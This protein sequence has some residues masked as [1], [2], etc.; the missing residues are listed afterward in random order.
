MTQLLSQ[1]YG[2]VYRIDVRL[3]LAVDTWVM[4]DTKKTYNTRV[5]HY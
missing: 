4:R 5:Q 2:R 3:L 1:H